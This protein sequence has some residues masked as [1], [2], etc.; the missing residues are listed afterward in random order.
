[1]AIWKEINDFERSQLE[2][3]YE[4]AKQLTEGFYEQE[5]TGTA[6]YISAI[7]GNDANDGTSPDSAFQ[8]CKML[9]SVN[10]VA[11]DTVLFECGSIFRE[12][13]MEI[14]NGVSY[15]SYGQGN[16]PKFYG[17][18][19]ASNI[20][21]WDDLGDGVYRYKRYIEWHRDIGNIVFDGG[22]A[23][24]IK[25]QKC[26]D[27]D[28]TLRLCDVDNGLE[29]FAEIPSV[30]FTCGAQLP[31]IN[32]AFTHGE[33]GYIYLYSENGHPAKVFSSIEL[34]Q[35]TKIFNSQYTEN[36]TFS[37]LHF[38]NIGCFAIRT[39][40]CKN[41][42]VYNCVFEFIGGAILFGVEFPW[43]NY[44]TRYGNAI[45][46]WGG[47]DGV[48]VKNCYF[49]QMYD[50]GVTTQSNDLN[51]H[52]ENLC[53]EDNVFSR[54]EWSIE[55]W[56]G[57]EECR[58]TNISVKNNVC[59]DVGCGLSTQRPD[60]G[61]ESFFCS[62]G[63]YQRKNCSVVGNLIYGS[64]NSM[65]CCNE[66]RTPQYPD[67]IVMDENIYVNREGNQ[68]ALTSK[69]FPAYSDDLQA[70]CYCEDTVRLLES[71]DIEKNSLFYYC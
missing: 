31:H 53:Y 11:G 60:K 44:R 17:S 34:S 22:R 46:N 49:D 1:M 70:L 10:L 66:Y 52:Q 39:A 30:P 32:L 48:T 15:S 43:R 23:W 14:V 5:I 55:I 69:L 59:R 28:V 26:T 58:L 56:S 16:K 42:Q 51:A 27:N 38:L 4:Q 19:D 65:V 62:R 21:D 40:G 61:Y 41:M 33:D 54:T 2:R 29:T 25:I 12:T 68:F 67:G 37:N 20:D 3:R 36:V 64:V 47:C 7:N 57:G 8:H 6:Y 13:M 24:G 45:E 35:H 18:I 50:T 63:D 9:E 71:F